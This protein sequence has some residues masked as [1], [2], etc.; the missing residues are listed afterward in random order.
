MVELLI[1]SGANVSEVDYYRKTPLHWAA[2]KGIIF[3]KI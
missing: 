2:E 1:K 3:I